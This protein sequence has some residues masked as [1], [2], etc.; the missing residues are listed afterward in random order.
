[1]LERGEHRLISP[2]AI[3]SSGIDNEMPPAV[4]EA[5]KAR[6]VEMFSRNQQRYYDGIDTICVENII[7]Q[8]C[9]P[10]L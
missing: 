9:R 10:Y 3:V 4:G 8:F 6:N 2:A 1:M 5:N 7:E